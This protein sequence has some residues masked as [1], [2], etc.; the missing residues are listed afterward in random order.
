MRGIDCPFYNDGLTTFGTGERAARAMADR[1]G[2]ETSEMRVEHRIIVDSPPEAIFQVYADVENW[3]QWDP[4]TRASSIAG[5]FRTG[6]KGRLTPTQGS[7]VPMVLTSVVANRGYTLVARIPMFQMIV[8]HELRPVAEGT[9]VIHRARFAG[10]LSP[11]LGRLIGAR[12]HKGM[13]VTLFRLK[14]LVESEGRSRQGRQKADRPGEEGELPGRGDPPEAGPGPRTPS[15]I[16]ALI[17]QYCRGWSAPDPAEREAL[18][19]STLAAGATYCDPATHGALDLTG[20]LR[21]IGGIHGRW[22]GAT[23]VR[24]SLIDSHHERARFSWSLLSAQGEVLVAGQDFVLV[25][26]EGQRLARITGFFGPVVE[27]RADPASVGPG[28]MRP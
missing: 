26:V 20:L 14:T 7:T 24:T 13:P 19:K 12:A 27:W 21:Y 25:T 8:E 23:V 6:A 3:Y 5:G 4:D 11:F 9:E 10:L 16:E 2:A 28:E 18:L 17:D 22:P 15:A 1:Q